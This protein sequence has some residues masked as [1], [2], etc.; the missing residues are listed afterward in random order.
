MRPE[1]KHARFFGNVVMVGFG[2]IGQAT[3]PLL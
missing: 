3:L 1:S 2:S